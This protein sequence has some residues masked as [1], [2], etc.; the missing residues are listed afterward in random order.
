MII[1]KCSVVGNFLKNETFAKHP[2]LPNFYACP[3]ECVAYSSGARL[4]F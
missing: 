2:F 1:P 4:K 3:V